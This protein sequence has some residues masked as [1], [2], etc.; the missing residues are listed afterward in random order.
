[1][2]D[3]EGATIDETLKRMDRFAARVRPLV[4]ENV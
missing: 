3:Y 4:R 1:M 2:L